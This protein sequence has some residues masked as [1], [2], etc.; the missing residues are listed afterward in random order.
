MGDDSQRLGGDGSQVPVQQQG[1]QQGL[2][3]QGQATPGADSA[4]SVNISQFIVISPSIAVLQQYPQLRQHVAAAI[5]Q[6]IRDIIAP[7][8]ERSV[9]IACITTRELILKDFLFEADDAMRSAAHM[10]VQNLA[11]SLAL[12]TCKEP[13]RHSMCTHLRPTFQKM[14]AF[15]NE[16]V[17][18]QTLEQNVQLIAAENLDQGCTLI[19]KAA[20]DKAVHN[21]DEAL[22]VALQH[23][24]IPGSPINDALV[25]MQN[26]MRFL[27]DA[28]RPKREGGLQPHHRRVYED[29]ARLPRERLAAH[30]MGGGGNVSDPALQAFAQGG[31]GQGMPPPPQGQ[32]QQ[33]PPQGGPGAMPQAQGDL[34]LTLEKCAACMSKAEQAVLQHAQLSGSP[35]T[36]LPQGHELAQLIMQCR[37]IVLQSM[38][39]EEV[40]VGFAQ[41]LFVRLYDQ[42]KFGRCLLGVEWLL[43]CL[44]SLNDISKRVSKEVTGWVAFS[45]PERRLNRELTVVLV[46]NRLLNLSSPDYTKE[47]I[48]A[49]DMGRNL[50]AID[51]LVAVLQHVLVDK[52]CVG[53]GDCV[54][55]LDALTKVAQVPGRKPPDALVRLL[56]DARN[57]ARGIAPSGPPQQQDKGRRMVQ[58]GKG[59]ELEDLPAL[60][61]QMLAWLDKWVGQVQANDDRGALQ[62]VTQL[63]QQ[64]WLKGDDVTDRFF[65]TTVEVSVERCLAAIKDGGAAPYV[66]TDAVSK[67]IA[68]LLRYHDEWA[69][70]TSMGKMAMVNKFFAGIVKFMHAQHTE[71]QANFNQKPFHRLLLRLL[72]D[73]TDVA[74]DAVAFSFADVLIAVQPR[75]LPGFAFAWLELASHRQLMPRLLEV[76]RSKGWVL[77]HKMLVGLFKYMEPFLRTAELPEPVKLMYKG[78][79]RVLLV[80]LH[81]FPEFLCEYH[82]A[83]CDA[84]PPSCIQL[85][86]L[87]LSA[88]PRAI[89]L[90]DP[91]TTQLKVD[92]LPDI[93]KAP[94]VLSNYQAVLKQGNL[95]NELDSFLKGRGPRGFLQELP[96]QLL[97]NP[98]EVAS[99]G[100]RY[101]VPLINALVLYTAEHAIALNQGLDKTPTSGPSI[102]VYLK[103]VRDLDTEGRYLV[104]NGIANQLRFPNS[105]THYLS[106]VLLFLFQ[107]SK[108]KEIVREQVAA[109]P[110]QPRPR[111]LPAVWPC[112]RRFAVC[113]C[114]RLV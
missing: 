9:T 48:K 77:F 15:V 32:M 12:V 72:L 60:R 79:L 22:D 81:D 65:R 25:Q 68:M 21:M 108:D 57:L 38:N 58:V 87:I 84:I 85:R 16:A 83:L 27:P 106:C 73:L 33:A 94:A 40:A 114:E 41:K 47:V 14:A 55:L 67:L 8:V 113:L 2:P 102:D 29:F 17:D 39:R 51:A 13:L 107:S 111:C 30:P 24:R 5:N 53:T 3:Q 97:G 18:A 75:L 105:H 19:E 99:T 63:L 37:A 28:L 101:N 64:G 91:F 104:L 100:T 66:F 110:D 6:A 61:T 112:L 26:Y 56:E 42:S 59:K 95:H 49:L 43:A 36:S 78:M 92:L 4:L 34:L 52:R 109:P 98:A 76:K 54:A 7:V 62:V 69:R 20:T 10:M 90:P 93:A 103:L 96:N 35:L 44:A 46:S 88:F 71:R 11:G 50:A 23:R 89:V 70:S 1:L 31:P 82:L 80:L 74:G 45:D 86:N